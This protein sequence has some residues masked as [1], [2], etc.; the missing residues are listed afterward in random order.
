MHIQENLYY[1]NLKMLLKK[2]LLPP[3]CT[4]THLVLS[5]QT[6]VRLYSYMS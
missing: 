1:S 3:I 4:G 6:L 2:L 5:S